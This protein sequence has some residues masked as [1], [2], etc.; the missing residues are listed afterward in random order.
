MKLAL[1]Y[2]VGMGRNESITEVLAETKLAEELGF[3]HV[4]FIDSQNLA[5]DSVAMMILAAANT[6]RVQIGQGVTQPYTRH[7]AVLANS[8]A[9][10]DELSGG[11]AFL[12][13]AAGG[14]ALGVMG[15][16]PRS[17]AEL[18][19]TIQF[20]KDFTG[21]K[22][23]EWQGARMHSEWIRRPIPVIVGVDGPK[24]C[25][26]G[27]RMGDGVFIPGVRPDLI[28]W[29][30]KR[31]AEGAAEAG[32]ALEDLQVWTRTMVFVHDNLEFAREQVKSYA[33]TGAF[34]F[35]F[36][37]LRWK[38]D[39]AEAVKA[40]LPPHLLDEILTLGERYD[41]YQHEQRKAIHSAD[42]SPELIDSFVICGPASKCIEQ[43]QQ[44]RDIGV[45]RISM[46]TYTIQDKRMA[47]RRFVEE[48]FP[49]VK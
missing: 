40:M 32:K 7:P 3:D 28:Q 38:T 2:G 12:G 25:R 47:M 9:T 23:A 8:V 6:G 33:C 19:G 31:L 22:E 13:I 45:D 10:V 46:T 48:V 42:A 27:G 34:Q 5:R 21:G 37:T 39:D 15:K 36:G 1:K 20:F 18:E 16:Q 35:F 29:R 4:T 17:M 24:S 43:I 14:S 26:L 41:W 44:L 30:R 11:R 49:F